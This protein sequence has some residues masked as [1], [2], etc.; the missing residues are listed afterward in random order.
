MDRLSINKNVKRQV[1]LKISSILVQFS[2]QFVINRN[3]IFYDTLLLV[4]IIRY[5]FF[6]LFLFILRYLEYRRCFNSIKEKGK[7]ER[8]KFPFSPYLNR[9]SCPNFSLF[10]LAAIKIK[11]YFLEN[12]YLCKS[13]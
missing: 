13:V 8:I 11:I 5:F 10:N 3:I 1:A 4:L 12:I 7:K 2:T 6:F 9:E